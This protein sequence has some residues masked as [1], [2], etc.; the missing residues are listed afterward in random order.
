MIMAFYWSVV[1]VPRHAPTLAA[2]LLIQ[3]FATDPE[4][5]G[6]DRFLFSG[7]STLAHRLYLFVGEFR[8]AAFVLALVLGNSLWQPAWSIGP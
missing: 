1:L 5:P 3:R 7:F 8:N 4:I 2:Q 6:D